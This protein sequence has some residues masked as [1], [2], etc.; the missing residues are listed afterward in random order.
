M[1][2]IPR[3]APKHR[4]AGGRSRRRALGQT[5]VLGAVSLLVLAFMMSLSFNVGNVLNQKIRL[6]SHSDSMAYSMATVEARAMNYFAYTNRA[7]AAVLVAQMTLHAYMSIASTSSDIFGAGMSVFIQIAAIEAALC[8]ACRPCSHCLHAIQAGRIAN[9]YRRERNRYRNTVKGVESTF[10]LAVQ[11][12]TWAAD[13]IHV[14][15]SEMYAFM[16]AK[17]LLGR[18]LNRLGT[19]NNVCAQPLP[20]AVGA[21]NLVE[22][23][24]SLEG[25]LGDVVPCPGLP[26]PVTPASKRAPTNRGDRARIM[27][28]VGDAARPQFDRARSGVIGLLSPILLNRVRQ[29]P[30]SGVTS[31]TSISGHSYLTMKSDN[32]CS[33]NPKPRTSGDRVCATDSGRVNGW[34]R[35]GVGTSG[36]SAVIASDDAGGRHRPSGG[37]SGRHDRY[38]GIQR[39]PNDMSLECLANGG[40]HCFVNFRADERASRDFGQPHVYTHLTAN[41]RALRDDC[42]A[43]APWEITRSGNGT[44]TIDDGQRTAGTLQ[45]VPSMNGRAMSKAMAY[46]HRFDDWRAPPNMFDPYWRAKLHPFSKAEAAVV[47]A[48]AGDTNTATMTGGGI[49]GK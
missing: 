14:S 33:G 22:F 2:S 41:L 24:C 8:A 42:N 26:N 9:R 21:I 34:W 43:Q 4:L 1:A 5:M 29:I 32:S 30:G 45:L 46:F 37:H 31:V 6:Q 27:A 44:L 28:N 47:A 17:P 18:D 11:S 7:I 23:Q 48:A 13:L 15:Q 49:E 40:G 12:M 38:R 10:N 3:A 35:H 16:L 36:F 25:T 20:G 39:R 19:T